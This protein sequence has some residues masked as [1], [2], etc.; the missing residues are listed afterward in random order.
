MWNFLRN[1]ETIISTTV[2]TTF[3]Y[4]W[5]EILKLSIFYVWPNTIE[6]SISTKIFEI[7]LRLILMNSLANKF[8]AYKDD[9][10]P[11]ELRCHMQLL[12]QFLFIPIL[13]IVP[14]IVSNYVWQPLENNLDDIFVFLANYVQV[15]GIHLDFPMIKCFLSCWFVNSGAVIMKWIMI[16]VLLIYGLRYAFRF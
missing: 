16:L 15:N 4:A 9:G 8:T 2:W 1:Y 5:N 7:S 3:T 13:V 12:Y 14:L 6:Q 11:S 10:I